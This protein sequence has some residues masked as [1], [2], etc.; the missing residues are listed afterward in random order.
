MV[1][2]S[3]L[4]EMVRPIRDWW[5]RQ[6]PRWHKDNCSNQNA[7]E[8]A[9]IELRRKVG[10]VLQTLYPGQSTCACC[11][12]PWSFVESHTTKVDEDSGCFALCTWCWNRL[13]L[14]GRDAAIVDYYR[15]K[16]ELRWRE[17]DP[18]HVI[19]TAILS[20]LAPKAGLTVRACWPGDM[21]P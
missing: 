8:V 18:W 14:Y 9:E 19:E 4:Y 3:A 12:W 17:A 13:R 21:E 7:R 15:A 2:V 11:E 10:P 1:N 6:T 20:E 16:W 5:Y